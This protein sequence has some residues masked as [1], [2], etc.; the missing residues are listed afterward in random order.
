MC[1]CTYST[2]VSHNSLERKLVPSVSVSSVPSLSGSP[3]AV[4]MRLSQQQHSPHLSPTSQP[5]TTGPTWVSHLLSIPIQFGFYS[6]YVGV[7]QLTESD[8]VIDNNPSLYWRGII[9]KKKEQIYNN[10][11]HCF[12]TTTLSTTLNNL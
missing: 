4:E 10:C 1:A 6:S 5:I 9:D 12:W 3:S 7:Q 11:F 2:F 8:K